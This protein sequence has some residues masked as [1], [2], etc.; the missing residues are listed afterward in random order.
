MKD[1]DGTTINAGNFI[2]C[3][4]RVSAEAVTCDA[5]SVNEEP[6]DI[7][8]LTATFPLH[9]QPR[10]YQLFNYTV[11]DAFPARY[12]GEEEFHGLSVYRFEQ[13]VPETV[14]RT[15]DL[16]GHLVGSTE[17]TAPADI[18]YSNNRTVLVEPTSGLIVLSEE[19]PQTVLRGEDGETGATFL[20]GTFGA[21]DSIIAKS[22][23]RAE[24]SRSQ[25]NLIETVLPWT[26]TALGLVLVAVGIVLVVR[27]RTASARHAEDGSTRVAVPTA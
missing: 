23:Q 17:E 1:G 24:D 13:E 4:D 9:T 21:D 7:Q 15:A 27:S 25:I 20:G 12:V 26:L 16:P 11:G 19:S 3:L 10:D 14:V 22:V 2:V 18:V 8:G 5:A 6:A